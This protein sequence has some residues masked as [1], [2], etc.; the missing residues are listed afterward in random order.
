MVTSSHPLVNNMLIIMSI[1]ANLDLHL[2]HDLQHIE[3]KFF[4][5]LQDISIGGNLRISFGQPPS[6][7]VQLF[8]MFEYLLEQ[9]NL[10]SK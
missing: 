9:K 8:Q 5:L 7:L 3:W 1:C 2:Q 4:F 10:I 6:H